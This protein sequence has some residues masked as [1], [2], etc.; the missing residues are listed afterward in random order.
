MYFY[1]AKTRG[2]YHPTV[3]GPRRILVPQAG[4]VRPTVKVELAPGES[5]P[6]NDFGHTIANTSAEPLVLEVPDLSAAHPCTEE[7]NPAH[8]TDVVEVSDEEHAA[9]MLG[10][11]EGKEIVPDELGRPVLADPVPT[12]ADLRATFWAERERRITEARDKIEALED[13][14]E[15]HAAVPWRA[16]RKALRDM[17]TLS[18]GDWPTRPT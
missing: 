14:G 3:H 7:H 9:L 13:D 5:V 2:F 10:Q 15:A 4:W 8:P 12:A 6:V 16:Y 17:D 1:S 11:T 18:S